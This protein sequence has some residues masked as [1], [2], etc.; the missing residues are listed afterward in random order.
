MFCALVGI[1]A[2]L[3]SSFFWFFSKRLIPTWDKGG[4]ITS[5]LRREANKQNIALSAPPNLLPLVVKNST[6]AERMLRYNG[7][8]ALKQAVWHVTLFCLLGLATFCLFIF[9]LV[10]EVCVCTCMLSGTTELYNLGWIR[11]YIFVPANRTALHWQ[12]V[13]ASRMM[14]DR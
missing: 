7:R 13:I 3:A 4:K 8:E 5:E 11:V 9:S 10:H 2:S 1:C 6:K 14:I 12:V